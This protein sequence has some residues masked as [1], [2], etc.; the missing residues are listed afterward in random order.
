MITEDNSDRIQLYE[1][2]VLKKHYSDDDWTLTGYTSELRRKDNDQFF[3]I[4]DLDANGD[5]GTPRY[6]QHCLEIGDMENKLGPKIKRQGEQPAPDDDQWL[7]CYEC[8]RT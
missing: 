6:C 8:G 1:A 3:A 4:V 7:S 5:E 2:R